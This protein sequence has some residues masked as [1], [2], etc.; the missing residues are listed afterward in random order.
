[1]LMSY[2]KSH[3]RAETICQLLNL[4]KLI[5]RKLIRLFSQ[6]SSKN[7]KSLGLASYKPRFADCFCFMRQQPKYI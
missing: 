6:F 4:I 5:D 3:I 7:N 2:S 1:M